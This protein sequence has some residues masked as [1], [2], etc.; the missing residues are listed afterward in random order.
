[1]PER[2]DLISASRKLLRLAREDRIQAAEVMNALS[3]DEQVSAVCEAPIAMRPRLLGLAEDPDALIPRMPEAELCFT[4]KQV[5]VED[6]SW[7]LT[8]ASSEQIVACFDLD[9]WRGIEPDIPKLDSWLA[10][11]AEAGEKTL[12][13]AAQALDAEMV[14]LYLRDHADVELKPAGDEDW[15]PPAGGQTLE[16]QFYVIARRKNDDLAPLMKLL[17]V[18]FQEDYWLYFRMMQSV[19]AE[20]EIDISFWA[21]RWRSGRLEDL[22]FPSWDRSMAIYGHLRRDEFGELPEVATT[23]ESTEW[24][25][26]VWL[27]DLPAARDS[28]HSLFRA[29]SQ[30]D[31]SER[32]RFFY[33]FISLA[34]RIA[35]ADQLELGD[36]E[37]LPDTIEKAAQIASRGLEYIAQERGLSFEEVVRRAEVARLFRVGVNLKPEG[38]RPA[39]TDFETESE[40]SEEDVGD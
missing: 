13:R 1:M 17:R 30:L 6:A 12:L 10:S 18:L 37:T 22:G 20:M 8:H 27:T 3:L 32:S 38:V 26:P 15:Q 39:L 5:G 14:A 36:S 25:L 16:G 33:A 4:C 7:M 34:N 40:A 9:G 11:L 19:R 28:R 35:I 24:S 23:E 21:L 2:R 31:E 29:V